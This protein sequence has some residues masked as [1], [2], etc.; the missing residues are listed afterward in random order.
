MTDTIQPT[1]LPN[2][3][4]AEQSDAHPA[5][6]AQ[7]YANQYEL[8][9][10]ITTTNLASGGVHS[11]DTL[12]SPHMMEEHKI[13]RLL[14]VPRDEESEPFMIA[15]KA[16]LYF[17]ASILLTAMLWFLPCLSCIPLIVTYSKFK[18]SHNPKARKYA[19]YSKKGLYVVA[20]L[21][22]VVSVVFLIL[23]ISF[24]KI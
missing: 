24:V 2:F 21:D 5:Q 7:Q 15:K 6:L 17:A 16:K 9:T 19:K 11:Q 12:L 3:S 14:L 10:L 18:N 22:V 20:M 1:L 23:L 4:K 8:P 13:D